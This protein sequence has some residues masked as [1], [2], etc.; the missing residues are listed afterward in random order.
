MIQIQ[1]RRCNA[2]LMDVEAMEGYVEIICR[3]CKY[4]NKLHFTSTE[5]GYFEAP[6]GTEIISID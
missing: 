2:R 4:K 6:E 3:N 5:N 1:C